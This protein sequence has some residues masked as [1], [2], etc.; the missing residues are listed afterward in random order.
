MRLKKTRV[1][2][3]NGRVNGVISV[4]RAMGDFLMKRKFLMENA[5]EL[6]TNDELSDKDY[7]MNEPEVV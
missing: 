3:F 6:I 2:F 1:P 4:T 7:L 5:P